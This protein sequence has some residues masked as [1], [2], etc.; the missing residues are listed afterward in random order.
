MVSIYGQS[1]FTH[2]VTL[3]FLSHF[4]RCLS[5]LTGIKSEIIIYFI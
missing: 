4:R 3:V 2:N 5:D 1:D